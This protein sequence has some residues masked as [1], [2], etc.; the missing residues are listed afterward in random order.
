MSSIYS[1]S[2]EIAIMRGIVPNA[3]IVNK[4]GRNSDTDGP[5]DIWNG[6]GFYT[7]FPTGSAETLTIS[8]SSAEDGA[9]TQT[10]VLTMRI[11][12]LDTNFA[13]ITEDVTLNGTSGVTTVQSF[14]RMNRAY[15]LTAGSNTLNVGDITI[16]HTTT[17]A[18]VF[19]FIPAGFSQ[20]EI[21]GYTI[22]AGYTGY[23][24]TY[25]IAMNDTSANSALCSFWTREPSSGVRIIYPTRVSTAYRAPVEFYGGIAF[26]EKTDVMVRALSVANTNADIVARFDLVLFKN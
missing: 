10:G 4:F 2:D 5:E 13:S 11:T 14:K 19:A 8:S 25:S 21:A 20:T 24:K 12:G 18:N 26:P 1:L 16:K 23:L 7:G 9:G 6:G 3:F 15:A 17:T 22:P